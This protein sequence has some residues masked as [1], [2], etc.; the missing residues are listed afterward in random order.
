[1]MFIS[2]RTALQRYESDGKGNPTNFARISHFHIDE[3][4]IWIFST[5]AYFL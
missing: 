1:M 5:C 4:L 3:Y 2:S